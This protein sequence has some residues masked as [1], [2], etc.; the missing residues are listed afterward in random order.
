MDHTKPMQCFCF[1]SVG[2]LIAEQGVVLL[3]LSDLYTP[4]SST[5]P[6]SNCLRALTVFW[7]LLADRQAGKM[8]DLITLV[9][10]FGS[11]C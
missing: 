2:V 8:S 7:G 6:L 11:A 9:W 5:R 1:K 3:L 4:F 10:K